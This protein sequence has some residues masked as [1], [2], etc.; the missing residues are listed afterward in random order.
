[1]KNGEKPDLNVLC[2][3]DMDKKLLVIMCEEGDIDE[4]ELV[5]LGRLTD[6]AKMRPGDF[7]LYKL[8]R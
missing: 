1:M 3:F 7:D 5:I 2:V 8:S 6:Q 4:E